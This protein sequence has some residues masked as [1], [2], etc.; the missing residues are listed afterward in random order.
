MDESN[1]S[2]ADLSFEIDRRDQ[3]K[4]SQVESWPLWPTWNSH[5]YSMQEMDSTC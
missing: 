2:T 5:I 3:D 1:I 4:K